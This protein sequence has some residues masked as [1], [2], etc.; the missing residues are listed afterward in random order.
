MRDELTFQTTLVESSLLEL[1][2]ECRTVMEKR[3]RRREVE[4]DTAR[5]LAKKSVQEFQLLNELL[6]Q[7]VLE[8]LVDQ[9]QYEALVGEAR[10]K[11]IEVATELQDVGL[12]QLDRAIVSQIPPIVN[13]LGQLQD[14]AT[15]P[16]AELLTV[17]SAIVAPLNKIRVGSNQLVTE[18]R[19]VV[20]KRKLRVW[21]DLFA[22]LCTT[23]KLSAM[24]Q[25]VDL[26]CKYEI[27]VA[28]ACRDLGAR[29]FDFFTALLDVRRS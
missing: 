10:A 4:L 15:P 21:S 27:Q 17:M 28:I 14:S 6:T 5:G 29:S 8:P 2:T 24:A 1:I 20:F 13:G 19:D 9:A 25:A 7:E 18:Q 3:L 12:P 26:P 11:L 16:P 22:H 23:L